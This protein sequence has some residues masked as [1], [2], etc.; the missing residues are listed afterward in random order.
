MKHLSIRP[1][2]IRRSI[3]SSNASP[4]AFAVETSRSL[5]QMQPTFRSNGRDRNLSIRSRAAGLLSSGANYLANRDWQSTAN[6]LTDSRNRERYQSS[7]AAVERPVLL[8]GW[9]Q[10][11]PA[12]DRHP[13]TWAT[14]DKEEDLFDGEV[15]IDV[16]LEGFVARHF[17]S[18]TRGQRLFNQMAKQLAGLPRLPEISDPDCLQSLGGSDAE[19]S[20]EPMDLTTEA[21]RRRRERLGEKVV[22]KLAAHTDDELVSKLAESMGALP[23]DTRSARVAQRMGE[24]ANLSGFGPDHLAKMQQSPSQP[25][26]PPPRRQTSTSSTSSS[27]YLG[28]DDTNHRLGGSRFWADR[29]FEE[30]R[31]LHSIFSERLKA[32]WVYRSSGREVRIEVRPRLKGQDHSSS[33][34][35]STPLL[36]VTRLTTDATG[37]F[38]H[39]LTIPWHMLSAYCKHHP[40]LTDLHPREICEL[41]VRAVLE[42]TTTAREDGGGILENSST[43]ETTDWMILPVHEDG[44]RKVRVISDIDDTVKDTGVVLGA[45]RILRNVFVLPY[46]ECEVPGVAKWYQSMVEAGVGIHYITNAPLELHSLVSDF[47]KTVGLPLGHLTL[48]HYPSGGRSILTSWMEPAGERKRGRVLQVLDEFPK[49]DFILVGDSGELDLELYS[50][51]ASE[52]PHQVRAIFIRDVSSPSCVQIESERTFPS[53]SMAVERRGGDGD[54][55]KEG[56]LFQ[57]DALPSQ[58]NMSSSTLAK[59]ARAATSAE[60]ARGKGKDWHPPP[61]PGQAAPTS[62]FPPPSPYASNTRIKSPSCTTSLALPSNEWTTTTEFEPPRPVIRSGTTDPRLGISEVELKRKQTFLARMER[63]KS[64]LPRSTQLFLFRKG[65]DVEEIALR[66]VRELQSGT[67]PFDR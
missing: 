49:S 61:P 31:S 6:F 18:P 40:P 22:E 41:E 16:A 35:G 3:V 42:G 26:P 66:V 32:Y 43:N 63:A 9:V 64:I 33:H 52:R 27:S 54:G 20:D 17:D 62:S 13:Q 56:W 38:S 12:R 55:E 67:R 36:A 23:S 34:R 57:E 2:S 46:S 65:E 5:F 48:K 44:S 24:D 4:V 47:L 29:S 21:E 8:P 50:S 53:S 11:K 60:A 39:K 58:S 45:K 25:P 10:R 14:A 15:E 28:G 51:L 59:P 1:T 7:P 19:L 37:Q 30:I